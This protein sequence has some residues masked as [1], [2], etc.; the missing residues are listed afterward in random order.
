MKGISLSTAAAW[1]EM[2][3]RGRREKGGWRLRSSIV[4]GQVQMEEEAANASTAF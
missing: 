4:W 2:R 3:K 1:C